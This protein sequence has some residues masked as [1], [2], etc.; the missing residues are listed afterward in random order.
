M[1]LL[2]CNLRYRWQ[3]WRH[4]PRVVYVSLARLKWDDTKRDW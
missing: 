3:E 1:A 4:R 2:L